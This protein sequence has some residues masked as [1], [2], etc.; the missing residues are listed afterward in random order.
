MEGD[1][2]TRGMD[3][4]PRQSWNLRPGRRSHGEAVPFI[5]PEAL[6][7]KPVQPQRKGQEDNQNRK[8]VFQMS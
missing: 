6:E 1:K 8:G 4:H 5:P 2:K 3:V 7:V